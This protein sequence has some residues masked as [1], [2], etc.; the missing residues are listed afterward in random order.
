MELLLEYFKKQFALPDILI[1]PLQIIVPTL[2][3][4]IIM[5]VLQKL[6][7]FDV[8]YG[9]LVTNIE[10]VFNEA[11]DEYMQESSELFEIS[12]KEIN[13]YINMIE[14]HVK[15]I[16]ES[17]SKIDAYEEEVNSYLEEF[18]TL[19]DME[20]DFNSEWNEFIKAV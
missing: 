8:Q 11:N 18:N 20:I 4:N 1:E 9:L 19:F 15:E 10:R 13:T 14:D 16:Q 6:D 2:T 7:L 3:T 12:S 5:L 17:I